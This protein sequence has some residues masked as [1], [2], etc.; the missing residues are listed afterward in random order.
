MLMILQFRDGGMIE[1]LL[2]AVNRSRMRLITPGSDDTLELRLR[3]SAWSLEDG[4]TAEV[5]AVISDGNPLSTFFLDAR[6]GHA[7]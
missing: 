5:E 3:K 2:L 7:A 4:R 6:V 1:A